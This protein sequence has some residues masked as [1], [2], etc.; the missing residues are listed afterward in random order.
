MRW[1][2]P[3]CGVEGQGWLVT[4]H[5]LTRYVKDTFFQGAHLDPL[6][7]GAAEKSGQARWIDLNENE[8]DEAQLTKWTKQPAKRPGWKP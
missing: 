8:F 7:P 2:L 4:F 5:V 6:P 1:N 3:V